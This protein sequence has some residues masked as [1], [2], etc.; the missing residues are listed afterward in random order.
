MQ[1]RLVHLRRALSPPLAYVDTITISHQGCSGACCG[2]LLDLVLERRVASGY[3]RFRGCSGARAPPGPCTRARGWPG[4]WGPGP[5]SSAA[6]PAPEQAPAGQPRAHPTEQVKGWCAMKSA[7]RRTRETCSL[8]LACFLE[9][10]VGVSMT[11]A[12]MTGTA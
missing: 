1:H 9:A 12:T 10:I 3:S 5:P 2:Y 6:A 11:G 7:A 4:A 8:L